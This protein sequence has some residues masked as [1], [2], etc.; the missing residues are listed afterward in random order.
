M[1]LNEEYYFDVSRSNK[2]LQKYFA[3]L[4]QSLHGM[5]LVECYGSKF[6]RTKHGSLFLSKVGIS[7]T[8]FPSSD[9]IILLLHLVGQSA[10][11]LSNEPCYKLAHKKIFHPS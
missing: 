2:S 11:A 4:D 9:F 6:D 3:A 7:T 5:E 1:S 8:D 10:P